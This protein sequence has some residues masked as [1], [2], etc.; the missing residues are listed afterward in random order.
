M[1]GICP[2]STVFAAYNEITAAKE[3]AVHL[4]SGHPVPPTRTEN[5]LRDLRRA[6]GPTPAAQPG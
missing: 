2:P 6:F 4:F 1:D 5:Q 3:I